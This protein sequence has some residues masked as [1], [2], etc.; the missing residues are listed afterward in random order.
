MF[1]NAVLRIVRVATMEY[2]ANQDVKIEPVTWISISVLG[3]MCNGL[4]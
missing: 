3:S 4:Q 1:S 2:E